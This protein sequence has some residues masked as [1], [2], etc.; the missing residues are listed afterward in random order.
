MWH[1]SVVN[2]GDAENKYTGKPASVLKRASVSFH[3]SRAAHQQRAH[4]RRKERVCVS[5][6]GVLSRT[7]AFQ[8]PVYVGGSYAKTHGGEATQVHCEFL[9]HYTYKRS[10]G[11]ALKA[12][13]HNI[14][15]HVWDIYRLTVDR[16]N[17]IGWN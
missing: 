5:L 15:L 3:L 2:G 1:S 16:M 11:K 14:R 4:P 13:A 8:S 7:E 17:C 9:V 12:A 10:N 6:A